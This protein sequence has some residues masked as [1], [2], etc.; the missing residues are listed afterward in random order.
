VSGTVTNLDAALNGLTYKPTAGYSGSDSLSVSVTDPGD[1]LSAS[2]SVALTVKANLAPTITAPA[3]ASVAENGSLVFSKSIT[4]TDASAGTATQ[5]LTLTATHGTLRLG[6]TSGIKIVSGSNRSAS[7]TISG[8]LANLNA[9]L[10]GLTFTPTS[11]YTGSASISLKYTDEGDGLTGSAT[12][13]ITVSRNGR[14]SRGAVAP[15]AVSV[16]RGVTPLVGSQ[17]T[18]NSSTDDGALDGETSGTSDAQ[19]QWAGFMAALELL[20]R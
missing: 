17:T 16:E 2:D 14:A 20:V 7:M 10:N 4:V 18:S 19:T 13:A 9:A 6:T 1:G 11:R 15:G 3:T 8:T 5:Q 12:I